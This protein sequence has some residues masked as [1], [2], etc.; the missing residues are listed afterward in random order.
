MI[1]IDQDSLHVKC[2]SVALKKQCVLC[3]GDSIDY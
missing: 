2:Y 1:D 3:P